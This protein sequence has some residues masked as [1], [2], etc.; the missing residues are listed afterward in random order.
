MKKLF[1][2][3]FRALFFLSL[4]TP[5]IS[6]TAQ[7][8]YIPDPIFKSNLVGDPSINTNM[9]GNIQVSEAVAYTG[10]IWCEE[11]GIH[12]VTGVEAFIN[13]TGLH[14]GDNYISNMDLSHNPLL[15]DLGVSNNYLINLDLSNNPLIQNLS[16][17]GNYLNTLDISNLDSLNYLNCSSNNLSNLDLSNN[18]LLVSIYCSNNNLTNLALPPTGLLIDLNCSYNQLTT[19]DLS[20]NLGIGNLTV[21]GNQLTCLNLSNHTNLYSLDCTNNQLVGLDVQNGN[22]INLPWFYAYNNPNLYC[23]EVDDVAYSTGAWGNIDSWAVFSL[24]CGAP[25]A[26]FN[27]SAPACFGNPVLFFDNSWGVS[28]WLWNFGD[29]NTSTQQNPQ[30]TY[31]IPGNYNVT[32]IVD[33]CYTTDTTSLAVMQNADMFGHVTYSGGDVTNG[34]VIIYPYETYYISFDTIAITNLDVTGHYHFQN[35]P[36]GDYLIK[37]FAD[38]LTYPDL[39]PTY[40]YSDWAWDSAVVVLHG[41]VYSDTADVVMIELP[42]PVAGPGLLHGQI[43]EGPGFGRAQGDPIHG[44]DVKL[45]FTGSSVVVASTTTDANGEYFFDNMAFGN[46]T[47]YAD[48]PG[49]E[50]DSTYQLTIDAAN[51][52]FLN[53]DYIVDSNSVYI[54]QG[55]GIENYYAPDNSGL[56]IY[57][58][59]VKDNATIKYTITGD[60][61]VTMDICNLY[62]VKIQS[63]VNAH[64][65]GGDYSYAYNPKT[66]GLKPGIYFITLSVDG[67]T[68]SLRM[69]V[70]E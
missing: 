26:Y 8:V 6:L 60:A 18:L 10:S 17:S 3:T 23:I 45:G 31:I 68:R 9:D 50:R 24:N 12:D 54:V 14:V 13:L 35:I 27:S 65:P 47:I 32:L 61:K 69:I 48:I 38:S 20:T 66:N 25:T 42:A 44:V 57:P 29:G 7:N 33:N 43:V 52:Q 53:L 36:Q 39:I 55:I 41:C 70:L 19:I 49:L 64:L 21:S 16:C 56:M 46:Y 15:I 1:T 62:G 11:Y 37:V 67:K 63:L 59:P 40:S 2:F 28:S 4:I 34:Q 58:N 51:N 30:H 22:N 5:T